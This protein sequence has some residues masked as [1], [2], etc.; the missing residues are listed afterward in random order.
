MYW[1]WWC[2]APMHGLINSLWLSDTIWHQIS[3]WTLAHNGL[4]PDSN[5]PLPEPM[6][7]D[8]QWGLVTIGRAAQFSFWPGDYLPLHFSLNFR[9]PSYIYICIIYICSLYHSVHKFTINSPNLCIIG[10]EIFNWKYWFDNI[11]G[12]LCSPDNRAISWDTSGMEC[13]IKP[14][15]IVS[16]LKSNEWTCHTM[17]QV[18]KLWNKTVKRH[19]CSKFLY[20]SFYMR[21]DWMQ[22]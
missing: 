2:L 4:L 10:L 9:N 16:D 17:K 18:S 3:W 11:S 12:H 8:H 19:V 1:P 14:S 5:K 21:D 15:F 22:H 13:I 6:L 7:T 20:A